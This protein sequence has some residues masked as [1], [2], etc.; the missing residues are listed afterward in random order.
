[1]V[2][3]KTA[4]YNLRVYHSDG[5]IAAM[6]VIKKLFFHDDPLGWDPYAL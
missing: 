6:I 3:A 2:H 1:M 5:K 4:V